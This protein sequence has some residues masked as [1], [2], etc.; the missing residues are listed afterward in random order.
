MHIVCGKAK[1]NIQ[2]AEE[3]SHGNVEN[4]GEEDKD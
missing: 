4:I 2:S 3:K 1:K